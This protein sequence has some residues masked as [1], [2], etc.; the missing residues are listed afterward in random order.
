MPEPLGKTLKRI[1]E[2]KH[3]SIEE[4]SER[5]RIP[6]HIISILEEDRLSEIKSGFYARSFIKTYAAFLGAPDEPS[7][8]EHLSK[9]GREPQKKPETVLKPPSPAREIKQ[10]DFS[11]I[12][13]YKNL[14]MA[15]IIGILVFWMLSFAAGQIN[16]FVKKASAKK[17]NKAVVVKKEAP[18]I[19]P[20]SVELEVSASDNTWLKVVCDGETL[21]TG[22]FKKGGK[23]TWKAKKEIRLEAG[24]SG[25]IKMNIN[26]KPAVF[27]GKKG[28]KKEII[29][30]KNGIK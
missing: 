21:F 16:K 23:D 24:N 12:G 1:R 28:E 8:K 5:S 6:R 7:V 15:I 2:S 17:Q 26:G 30:T 9:S 10:I 4:V 11:S 25:A 29:V 3:L 27:S 14:I 19:K 22:L 18:N 13:K 20:D